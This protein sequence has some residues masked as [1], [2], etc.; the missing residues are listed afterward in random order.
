VFVNSHRSMSPEQAEAVAIAALG[1]LARDEEGLGR[2]LA[3]T[4][5]GPETLRKA[6]SEPWFLAAVLSHLMESEQAVLAF[7]AAEGLKPDDVQAAHL[8]LGG[9]APSEFG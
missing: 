3:L 2:F 9:H 8:A 5:L 7:A 6:A 1:F 4:G